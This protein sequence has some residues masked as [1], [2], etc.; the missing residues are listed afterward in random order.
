MRIFLFAFTAILGG[1][2]TYWLHRHGKLVLMR[3]FRNLSRF[4]VRKR[5][6]GNDA[7]LIPLLM[8][9]EEAMP[10]TD[11]DDGHVM[12]A[13]Q[14][15]SM[16]GVTDTTPLYISIKGRIYDVSAAREMYGPGKSY[17]AFVGKDATRAFATGCLEEKCI[18]SSMDGLS[19]SEMK[20]IDRWVELYHN[21]DKYKYIGKLVDDHI[22]SMV[23]EEILHQSEDESDSEESAEEIINLEE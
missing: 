15:A 6:Y 7:A 8:G 12:T 20:E 13:E 16:N 22:D 3:F 2:S 9:K 5:L 14:L 10:I 1:L 11:E 18:S 19:D 23:D 21:H 17:Y 4:K